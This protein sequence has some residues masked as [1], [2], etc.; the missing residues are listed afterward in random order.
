M[1]EVRWKLLWGEAL[2]VRLSEGLGGEVEDL[3]RLEVEEGVFEELQGNENEKTVISR[4][5]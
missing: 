3:S 5:W 2:V 1:L 4:R